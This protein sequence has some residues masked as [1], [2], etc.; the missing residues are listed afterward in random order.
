MVRSVLEQ[1]VEI[2]QEA[3]RQAVGQLDPDSLTPHEAGRLLEAF[4]QVVRTAATGSTLLARRVE[5]GQ[6]WRQAG[7]RTAAEWLAATSGSSIGS[8]RRKMET[9]K[10]LKDLPDT[11]KE[12]EQGTI[13]PDQGDTIAGAAKANPG[14]EKRLLERAK[15]AN[16]HELREEALRAKAEADRSAKERHDRLHRERRVRRYTDG[17]GARHLDICGPVDEVSRIEA[18]L[19]R[20]LGAVIRQ[21]QAGEG[22]ESRDALAFD[23]MVAMARRS[24]E[25][26]GPAATAGGKARQPAPQ[27]L[28]LL[29]LDISALWRGYVEG[30]ELCEVA[31]LGPIPVG[32]AR[33]LL[34]DAVL[35]LIITKGEAVAHVTSLT[36]GPTQAM[37]YA[38]LWT[39]PTCVVEGCTRTI[40]EHDHSFGAEYKDTRHTRLHDLDRVCHTHHDLHTYHGWALVAGSGKRPMVPPDD[41]AHPG[42]ARARPRAGPEPPGSPVA[43]RPTATRAAPRTRAPREPTAPRS[44]AP[45]PAG[46]L[47]DELTHLVDHALM[48]RARAVHER[49]QNRPAAQG[50]LF[51]GG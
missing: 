49:I 45:Q 50:A 10:A 35:K 18:E 22:L 36:R 1:R 42:Q 44:P 37:R 11:R 4:D 32:V 34:G 8:A 29:R 27:H 9:S 33:R 43:G 6:E 16:L 12:M 14:A 39:S 13:S 23:A 46:V 26:D 3:L 20:R 28:A 48:Q 41:P 40:V 5:D 31:G 7:Y 25:A 17:E 38:L 21:R 30:E 51:A 15:K 19:D 24:Q 2:A 47:R